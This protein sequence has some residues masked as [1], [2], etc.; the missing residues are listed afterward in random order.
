MWKTTLKYKNLFSLT[1]NMLG[2]YM[3]VFTH[4]PEF[5]AEYTRAIF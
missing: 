5:N 2:S 1:S 3:R 4:V